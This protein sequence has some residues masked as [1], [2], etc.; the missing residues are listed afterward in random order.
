M[1]EIQAFAVHRRLLFKVP[2]IKPVQAIPIKLP[3]N[4]AFIPV[5]LMSVAILYVFSSLQ[6]GYLNKKNHNQTKN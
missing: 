2:Q 6:V 3:K 1:M 4:L 5:I